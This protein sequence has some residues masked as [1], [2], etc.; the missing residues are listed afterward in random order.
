MAMAA[1]DKHRELFQQSDPSYEQLENICKPRVSL[2]GKDNVPIPDEDFDKI[3]AILYSFGKVEWSKRPRMYA[4]LWMIG[5][6]SDMDTFITLGH[7]DSLFPYTKMASL[8]NTLRKSFDASHS[9]LD[10]QKFV[11][12]AA[13]DLEKVEGARH[14]TID[15]GDKLFHR[16]KLPLGE[17]GSRSASHIPRFLYMASLTCMAC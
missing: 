10:H 7:N 12:T 8:P 17:G 2:D 6:V 9:F 16:K 11:Y 1:A 4:V 14:I 3:S 13:C 5:R 15:K